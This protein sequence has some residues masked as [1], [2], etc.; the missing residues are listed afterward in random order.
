MTA[1]SRFTKITYLILA[2]KM[3]LQISRLINA[4]EGPD[5]NSVI[6]IDASVSI[7]DFTEVL[8][9]N[10]QV[11][12]LDERVKSSW[13]SYDMIQACLNAFQFI[14]NNLT[15][16][17]IILLSGQDY[18]IKSFKHIHSYFSAN[19]DKIFINY[20]KLPFS[21]RLGGGLMRFPKIPKPQYIQNLY[22]GSQWWSFPINLIHYILNFLEAHPDYIYYFK[23]VYLP[24]ESFFQT[25][26]LNS[27][28]NFIKQNLV[29]SC[30]K[31]MRWDA[32]FMHPR[33]LTFSDKKIITRSK[34]LF[35]RKF[36]IIESR[37]ILKAI[38]ETFLKKE[39]LPDGQSDDNNREVFLYIIS[40][41][42]KSP[43]I[44]DKKFSA[45]K[46]TRLLYH[47]D[48][49]PELRKGWPI[50]DYVAFSNEILHN[51]GYFAIS[52]DIF[53]ANTH[54]PLLRFFLEYPD[55]EYY[56]IIN[57]EIYSVNELNHFFLD[58]EQSDADF[59]SLSFK[60]LEELKDWP[61]WQSL[62]YKLKPLSDQELI[63]S[64]NT[65]YRISN[66]ALEF[67]HCCLS[68]GWSGHHEVLLPSLLNK[69]GFNLQNINIKE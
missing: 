21:K 19:R 12:F 57:S 44:Y 13:A 11:Y 20:V 36:D 67:I 66:S 27:T 10:K 45:S 43:F 15:T 65:I 56:W 9:N 68:A 64:D 42:D 37:S 23:Q 40:G 47:Q 7:D 8:R 39:K 4:L 18:P 59:L 35:A 31:M 55:Y 48:S 17:R 54:F 41:N 14:L 24:D 51:L 50:K 49:N 28:E 32:P 63:K 22:S 69:A 58:I 3:P 30:L 6:H 25:L 46:A 61:W 16:D 62:I 5:V 34:A 38:D 53:P 2:H 60:S 26:L 29:N 33:M 52:E 1:N